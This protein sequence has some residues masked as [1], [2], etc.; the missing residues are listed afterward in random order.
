MSV[1]KSGNVELSQVS[2]LGPQLELCI[3]FSIYLASIATKQIV[4]HSELESMRV[5]HPC[6]EHPRAAVFRHGL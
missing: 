2:S 4:Y 6:R 5:E 3:S 1:E